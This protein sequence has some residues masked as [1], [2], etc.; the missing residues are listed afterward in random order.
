[1]IITIGF[2]SIFIFSK[3]IWCFDP[4]KIIHIPI[5]KDFVHYSIEILKHFIFLLTKCEK[6]ANK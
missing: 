6:D 2:H 5:Y 4:T 1:M 3:V